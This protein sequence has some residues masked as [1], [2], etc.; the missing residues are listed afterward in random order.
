MNLAQC[1][2]KYIPALFKITVDTK[3]KNISVLLVSAAEDINLAGN[4]IHAATP[5]LELMSND[6]INLYQLLLGSSFIVSFVDNNILQHNFTGTNTEATS[7]LAELIK[8]V[9]AMLEDIL[10]GYASAQIM[11]GSQ[12][13]EADTMITSLK[14][15][16]KQTVCIHAIFVVNL[17]AVAMVLDEVMRARLGK[18]LVK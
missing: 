8:S 6:Q 4:I 13:T 5:Q 2:I 15:K 1:S 16:L 14:L 3:T 11:V 17:L 10:V 12:L 18:G 9:S 7:T